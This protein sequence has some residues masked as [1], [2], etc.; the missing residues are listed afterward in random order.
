M[1]MFTKS[2]HEEM[3]KD[4]VREK[5]MDK[6]KKLQSQ[7]D[8]LDKQI[9]MLKQQK[10]ALMVNMHFGVKQWTRLLSI[11]D[12]LFHVE[13]SMDDLDFKEKCEYAIKDI[14]KIVKEVED[15]L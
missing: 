11:K 9:E 10:E 5:K 1:P 12:M 2:K 6:L 15:A 4:I 13:N 8:D 3:L 14:L 7:S